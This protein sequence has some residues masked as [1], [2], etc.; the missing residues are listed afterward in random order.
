MLVKL[1]GDDASANHHITLIPNRRLPGV[2]AR[3][4]SGNSVM[5]LGRR[6]DGCGTGLRL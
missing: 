1:R 5:T 3:W 2:M 4:G 6:A